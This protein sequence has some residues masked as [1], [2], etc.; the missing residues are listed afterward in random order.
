LNT[1]TFVE[2]EGKTTIT[3]KGHGVRDRPEDEP[4][5]FAEGT[6][7][8]QQEFKGTLD[9]LEDYWLDPD[10]QEPTREA[11]GAKTL[12]PSSSRKATAT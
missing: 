10:F 8:A 1:R 12:H 11:G 3:W 6:K 7:S 5:T 2:K 9:Q 4:K